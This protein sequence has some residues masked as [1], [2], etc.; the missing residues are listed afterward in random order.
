MNKPGVAWIISREHI[1]G[2]AVRLIDTYTRDTKA[3]ELDHRKHA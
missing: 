2:L 3:Y 1:G